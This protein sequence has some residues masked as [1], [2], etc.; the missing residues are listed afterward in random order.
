M[1]DIL[2]DSQLTAET[3]TEKR[4]TKHGIINEGSFLWCNY[5]L[6]KS[7]CL[8]INALH[9]GRGMPL[10]R[11]Y[12]HILHAYCSMLWISTNLDAA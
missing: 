10:C 12:M 7:V 11:M 1:L 2:H 3:Q 9:S 4:I 8:R 6:T 5:G